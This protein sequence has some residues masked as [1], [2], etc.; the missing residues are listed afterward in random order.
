MVGTMFYTNCHIF[1]VA[2]N[3]CPYTDKQKF[4]LPLDCLCVHKIVI[5]FFECTKIGSLCWFFLFGGGDICGFRL[6]F[7]NKLIFIFLHIWPFRHKCWLEESTLILTHRD[8][9]IGPFS[10]FS[11]ISFSEWIH[12]MWLNVINLVANKSLPMMQYSVDTTT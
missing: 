9:C 1:Q 7:L 10:S 2:E 11:V 4:S 3:H 5:E 12:R 8:P 6:Y